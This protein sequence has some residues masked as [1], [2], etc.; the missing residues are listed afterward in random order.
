MAY[1]IFPVEWDTKFFGFPVGRLNLPSDFSAEELDETLNLSR[2]DY[3]LVYVFL[4]GKGPDTLETYDSDCVCYDR[5]LVYKKPVQSFLPELDP[6][7]KLYTDTTC[8]RQLEALAIASGYYTRFRRD[9]QLSSFYERLFVT[10]MNNSVS[11]GMA[12]S[13]WTWQGDNG[14]PLGLTTIRVVKNIVQNP[15]EQFEP[16]VSEVIREGRLG[17]L[18][19]DANHRR[20]GIAGNLLKACEFWCASLGLDE[21]SIV[22][23]ADCPWIC[24]MCERM[25]YHPGAEVSVYHHWSTN[26]EYNPKFGWKF[27]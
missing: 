12:D 21:I 25:G 26:W 9:P 22:A 20:Q 15:S 1:I 18:A 24:K 3:R 11:G 10:W 16:N 14:K 17:M 13:I 4:K 23:A 5:R 7:L 2:T 8:S 27:Q 19:V 6:H